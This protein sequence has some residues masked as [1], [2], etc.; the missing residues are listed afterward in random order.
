MAVRT[1]PSHGKEGGEGINKNIVA[2]EKRK[3]ERIRV[4]RA[5]RIIIT[6]STR[7]GGRKNG[8]KERREL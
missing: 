2:V 4:K 1:L 6:I 8:K 3:G 5:M 7:N